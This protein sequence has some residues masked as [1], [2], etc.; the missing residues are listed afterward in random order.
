MVSLMINK[1]ERRH[2]K[3]IAVVTVVAAVL[4]ACSYV[5]TSPAPIW[6]GGKQLMP[7]NF[8]AHLNGFPLP[9]VHTNCYGPDLACHAYLDF[10]GFVF[11]TAMW[12]V[13]VAI[14]WYAYKRFTGHRPKGK[15]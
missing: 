10:W 2:I 4:S 15:K 14:G 13:V 5:A 7:A 12:A 3:L 8:S 1:I 6:E 9:F 11:N